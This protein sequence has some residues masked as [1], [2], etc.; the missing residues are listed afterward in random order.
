L[1]RREIVELDD[2]Y[3]GTATHGKKRGRGTEKAKVIVDVS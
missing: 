3:A 2:T 1:F